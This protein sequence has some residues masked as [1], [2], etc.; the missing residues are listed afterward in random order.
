LFAKA[1]FPF[2]G[3][4]FIYYLFIMKKSEFKKKWYYR[5][6]KILYYSLYF[7][8][9]FLSISITFTLVNISHIEWFLFWIFIL[10]LWLFF[11]EFIRSIFYYILF[12]IWDFKERILKFTK[13]IKKDK[14]TIWITLKQFIF[15]IYFLWFLLLSLGLEILSNYSLNI[16][17]EFILQNLFFIVFLLWLLLI[18][19]RFNNIWM[20]GWNTLLLLIPFYNI[21]LLYKLLFTFSSKKPKKEKSI[22][23]IILILFIYLGFLWFIYYMNTK[24]EW[25]IENNIKYNI[26]E[27]NLD[28]DFKKQLESKHL[29]IYNKILKTSAKKYLVKDFIDLNMKYDEICFN[30]VLWKKQYYVYISHIFDIYYSP[31]YGDCIIVRKYSDNSYTLSF[32]INIWIIYENWFRDTFFNEYEILSKFEMDKKFSS[33]SSFFSE[34]KIN[35]FLK[36]LI[37]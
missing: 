30:E 23:M 32:L 15:W 5:L 8:T 20:S 34:W 6:L 28:K 24:W 31:K 19:K 2:Y 21:F 7:L 3:N 33:Y 4:N 17:Y 1:S 11:I 16:L 13:F 27:W 22:I 18:F 37:K 9:I 25:N 35:I 10:P 12:W 14:K 36:K 26:S 29:K